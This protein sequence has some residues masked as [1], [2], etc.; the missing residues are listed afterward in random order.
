MISLVVFMSS[1][2]APLQTTP[3]ELHIS[4][5]NPPDPGPCH[6]F[7]TAYYYDYKTDSC[8]SFQ[9]GGCAGYIPFKSLEACLDTCGITKNPR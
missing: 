6:T 2:T 9:Y 4:C 5:L 1:C 3:G 8:R 7:V